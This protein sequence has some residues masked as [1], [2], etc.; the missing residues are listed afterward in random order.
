M[1]IFPLFY[2]TGMSGSCSDNQVFITTVAVLPWVFLTFSSETSLIH[3]KMTKGLDHGLEVK[4]VVVG[5]GAVGK[6]SL[7]MTYCKDEF[8]TE[9]LPTVF[10]N[11]ST[12]LVVDMRQVKMTLWDTAGQEAYDKMRPLSYPDTDVF[13]VCFSIVNEDSL[14]N[15]ESKWVPELR[16]P[17]MVNRWGRSPILLVGLKQDLRDQM[18]AVAVKVTYI[19]LD[20]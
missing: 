11:Y 5:D 4:L 1:K 3:N 7:L 18:P 12:D 10:D 9:Y 16:H 15:V 20:R 13:L 19:D 14:A 6:T 2:E 8:P 17:A